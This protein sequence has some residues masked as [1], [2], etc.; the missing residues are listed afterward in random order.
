MHEDVLKILARR[1]VRAFTA[2]PVPDA[3]LRDLLKAAMSAPSAAARDPWHFIVV[4][5]PVLL[6]RLAELLPHGTLIAHAAAGIVVCGDKQAAH[7][8]DL[9]YLL[10]DCSAATENLLLA[11]SMMG[12]GACWLGIHPNRERIAG[13][14]ER[15]G[16]PSAIIPVA[17]VALG[18]P[19]ERPAPRTRYRTDSVHRECW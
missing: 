3:T 1:S 7:R 12:L 18:F 10:Q 16:L 11:A 13:F 5:N 9:S 15:L 6:S 4:R 17:A 2:Q 8:Q 19:Q 14:R